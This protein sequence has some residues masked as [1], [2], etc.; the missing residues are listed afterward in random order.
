M[1]LSSWITFPSAMDG[2]VTALTQLEV[3]GV[4][5]VRKTPRLNQDYVY[6]ISLALF[7]LPVVFMDIK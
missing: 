6:M 1:A 2:L 7:S 3:S 5:L 4:F